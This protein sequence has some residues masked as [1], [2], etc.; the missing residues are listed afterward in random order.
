ME[1]EQIDAQQENG[2]WHGLLDVL[3]KI[4]PDKN[5]NA[6]TF[7]HSG[8]SHFV[9]RHSGIRHFVIRHSGIKHFDIRHSG[10]NSV[11]SVNV[12]CRQRKG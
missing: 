5:H 1:W 11:T 4:L 12:N 9:I 6:N 7:R 3:H 8:I 10:Y 2:K